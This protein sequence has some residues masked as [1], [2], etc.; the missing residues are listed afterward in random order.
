[1]K[2]IKS[3]KVNED[4]IDDELQRLGFIEK[5]NMSS[6]GVSNSQA[7]CEAVYVRYHVNDDIPEIV[8]IEQEGN[9]V[10]ITAKFE[11]DEEESNRLTL[12]EWMLFGLKALQLK[13]KWKLEREA[14]KVECEE[15][16]ER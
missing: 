13:N 9:D 14:Y 2:K 6:D 8:D 12:E 3:I 16:N 7:Y 1:M 11:G 5:V 4:N 15:V 10:L